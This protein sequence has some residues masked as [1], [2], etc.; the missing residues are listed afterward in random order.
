MMTKETDILA[1][2]VMNALWFSGNYKPTQRTD[3]TQPEEEMNA[4][5]LAR[6]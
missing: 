3:F 6:E 1:D 4:G 2:C 5:K